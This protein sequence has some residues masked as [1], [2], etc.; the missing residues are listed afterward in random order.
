M[1]LF[2]I[3]RKKEKAQGPPADLS[4]LKCDIHSHFIPGIDDGAQTMED[5]MILLKSL[6]EFGYKKAITTPHIM[7]DHFRNTPE[8]IRNGLDE[9]RITLKSAS[10]RIDVDAAAE[11]YFDSEFSSKISEKNLMTFGDRYVLFELSYLN[12]PDGLQEIIF[13]MQTSGYKP[14]LAH[15]E[16]YPFWY[17]SPEKYAEIKAKGVLLQLNIN[18]LTGFYSPA[19]KKTAEWLIDQN[20]IDFLGTDCHHAGHIRLMQ[21]A[22]HENHLK[23]LIDSGRLLNPGLI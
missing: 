23:K 20:L 9:L 11:Y 12:A 16:R 14:V 2:S 1:G 10:Y 4:L 8:I 21:K 6:E 5:S 22:V 7:G 13:Q 15:P 17:A 18:S 3:F 19:A